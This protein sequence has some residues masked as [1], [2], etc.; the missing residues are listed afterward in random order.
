MSTVDLGLG[1]PRPVAV[2]FAD[3]DAAAAAAYM[4]FIGEVPEHK[5]LRPWEKLGEASRARWRVVAAAVLPH[6][7]LGEAS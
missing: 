6:I 3:P 7:E 2:R 5:D 1:K 4:A